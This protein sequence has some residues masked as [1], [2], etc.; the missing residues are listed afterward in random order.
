MSK[1]EHERCDYYEPDCTRHDSSLSTSTRKESVRSGSRRAAKKRKKERASKARAAL[2]QQHH[3]AALEA[4][5]TS[6]ETASELSVLVTQLL[7]EMDTITQRGIGR[8]CRQ[9][10]PLPPPSLPLLPPPPPPS[11]LLLPRLGRSQNSRRR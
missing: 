10:F 6:D 4:P 1:R 3:A 8:V 11:L 9:P 5:P 2:Q 7:E